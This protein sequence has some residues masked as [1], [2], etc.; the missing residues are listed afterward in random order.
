MSSLFRI[1]RKR[2]RCKFPYSRLDSASIKQ[3]FCFVCFDFCHKYIGESDRHYDFCSLGS[4]MDLEKLCPLIWNELSLKVEHF[5]E[6]TGSE[7]CCCGIPR[8][9]CILL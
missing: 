5:F 9:F 1:D 6:V 7:E 8:I 3:F 2:H 4:A